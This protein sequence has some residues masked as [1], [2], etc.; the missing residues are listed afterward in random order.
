MHGVIMAE[1]QKYVETKFDAATWQS[2]LSQAG[3][4][5]RMYLPIQQYPD[6]EAVAIVTAAS[7]ATGIPADD[8]LED[9]GEFIAPDLIAM[10][11]MLVAPE[12]KTLDVLER[13]EETIHTVV[14]IRNPG[15]LPPHLKVER[16]GPDSVHISYDSPRHMCAVA[17][18][19][20]KGLAKYFDEE[21]SISETSCMNHGD[22]TCEID[23]RLV[24]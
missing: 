19:I 9:Y 23:I 24:A 8:I 10:Y 6:E 12:W 14:R 4:G 17:K 15:A 5:S 1:L 18:G 22:P 21:I 16:T 7:Q 13:T 11:R 3:L 20:S 2:L